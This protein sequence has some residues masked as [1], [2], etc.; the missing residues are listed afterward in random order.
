M[1]T[2]TATEGQRLEQRLGEALNGEL[3]QLVRTCATAPLD[4][5]DRFLTL[6]RIY[7]HLM[8]PLSD[9]GPEARLVTHPA[10][11]GLKWR[12]ENQ[13]LEEL[14][15]HASAVDGV[16]EANAVEGMRTL[17]ARDRLPKIYRWIAKEADREQLIAFLFAEG[18][19]DATFDD[20]VAAGQLGLKGE[21]K[22][23]MARN[24]WNEMG[25][26]VSGD[27]HT[28]L[29]TAMLAN[30]GLPVMPDRSAMTERALERA[31]LPGL[32][33]SNHWLQPELLGALG[34]VEL[35][36]GPRCQL[37][38]KAMTR[39]RLPAESMRFYQVHCD[40]DPKHGTDWLS[41]VIRPTLR[42]HPAWHYRVIRG[43]RW[44]LA[45]ND[46]FLAELHERLVTGSYAPVRRAA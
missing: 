31:A 11:T 43:A 27:V 44:R 15:E 25:D 32:L 18:G 21:A 46:E 22:L 30:L 29:H 36:A 24:Y 40:I 17:A 39:L 26:G 41:Q 12:L 34:M 19:P 16:S 37:V 38:I 45:L 10:V 6:L 4:R 3:G 14:S 33:A 35:Q 1:S 7:D 13:W 9:E 42:K 28:E 23:E 2:M 5:S 20:L 8:G